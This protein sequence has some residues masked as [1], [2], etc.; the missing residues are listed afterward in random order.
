MCRD[1][2]ESLFHDLPPEDA[3]RWHDSLRSHPSLDLWKTKIT[4][5]GWQEV[6]STYV[7]CESDRLLPVTVQEKFAKLGGSKI[8]SLAA[9]HMAHLSA[10]EQVSK[11]IANEAITA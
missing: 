11:I 8:V 5:C 9:G 1:S 10:T 6:P 2:K 7:I 4:Y 3:Q